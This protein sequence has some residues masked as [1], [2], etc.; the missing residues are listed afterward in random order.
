[1]GLFT[2]RSPQKRGRIEMPNT[3]Q[4]V[5][6]EIKAIKELQLMS[7]QLTT[8][9]LSG[10]RVL[11]EGVDHRGNEGQQVLDA[12]QWNSIKTHDEVHEAQEAF[13]AAVEEF[14]AP[15]TEAADAFE[16]AREERNAPDPASYVVIHEAVE[17][18][19]ARPE[20]VV[21]LTQDSIILRL[22]EEGQADRLI[23][24]NDVLEVLPA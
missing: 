18:V 5:Q 1:M 20:F 10:D 8:T 22:I 17:G 7:T 16:A 19:E 24:V 13:D 23:W 2:R 3:E 15:L 14:F 11:V 9:E 21:P 4:T 6:E 12:T